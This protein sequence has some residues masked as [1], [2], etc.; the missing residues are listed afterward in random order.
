M[1]LMVSLHWLRLYQEY[2]QSDSIM[3]RS[4]ILLLN[5]DMPML[6]YTS[7]HHVWLHNVISHSVVIRMIRLNVNIVTL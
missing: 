6:R 5:W 4:G 3:R 7:V 2:I 1:W